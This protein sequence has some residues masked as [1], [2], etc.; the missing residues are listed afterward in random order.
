MSHITETQFTER[1]AA[2]ILNGKE[3]PKKLPDRHILFI[4]SILKLELG[5]RYTESELNDELRSWAARF[6]SSSGLDHVALRRFLV[7]EKYLTR[8]S[9]GGTYELAADGLPYTFDAS[10]RDLDLDKLVAAAR[11]ARELK[12]QQFMNRSQA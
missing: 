1:F 9:A 11:Q 3:L 6:G 2:L 5:R 7:D 4:S 10:L 12:K 8:D